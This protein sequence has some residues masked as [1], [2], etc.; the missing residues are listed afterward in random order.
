M[1]FQIKRI[2]SSLFFSN[3]ICICLKDPNQE[4]FSGLWQFEIEIL[5]FK[6]MRLFSDILPDLKKKFSWFLQ[7]FFAIF[8]WFFFFI[9]FRQFL[10]DLFT[11]F[12]AIFFY[13]F[14][15]ISADFLAE[16]KRSSLRSLIANKSGISRFFISNDEWLQ[17]HENASHIAHHKNCSS[18][19]A[20]F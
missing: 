12:E 15:A 9:I 14:S 19:A 8:N 20:N 17:L 6:K 5:T 7:F 1:S 16:Y 11:I 3:A 18:I 13:K 2:S 10:A 4:C